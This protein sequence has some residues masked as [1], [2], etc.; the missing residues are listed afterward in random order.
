MFFKKSDYFECIFDIKQQIASFFVQVFTFICI[1][2]QNIVRVSKERGDDIYVISFGC[3]YNKNHKN[4]S[5]SAKP[6]WK[7]KST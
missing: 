4:T 3:E 7:A 1:K 2:T 5:S 6:A